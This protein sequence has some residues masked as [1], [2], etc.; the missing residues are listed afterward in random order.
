MSP[1]TEDQMAL[2]AEQWG[3]VPAREVAARLGRSYQ[4]V[5]QKAMKLGLDAGRSHTPEEVETVRALYR[6]HTAVEIAEQLYGTVERVNRVLKIVEK[7]GLRKW[8]YWSPEVLQRVR[9]LHAEGLLDIQIARE[10]PDVF[11][12]GDS[13]RLQVRNIRLRLGLTI[14]NDLR[15]RAHRRFAARYG[16]SEDLKP[17]QVKIVLALLRG[18]LTLPEIKAALGV[19]PESGL[20][21][22]GANTTY[23]ADLCRRGLVVRTPTGIGGST[24]GPRFRYLL[25]VAC[26]DLLAAA[27]QGDDT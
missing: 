6:T 3:E 26:L 10:M 21:L 8:R 12:P 13:G 14:P 18:P 24:P 7:L 25:T 5:K 15:K 2:L 27:P 9:A 20:A 22:N 1:W 19:R 16:L 23:Q 4:A 17:V 11:A